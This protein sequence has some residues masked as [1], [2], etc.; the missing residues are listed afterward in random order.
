MMNSF[1]WSR[2]YFFHPKVD[3]SETS[4]VVMLKQNWNQFLLVVKACV[5][6]ASIKILSVNS[7]YRR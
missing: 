5:K 1:N 2:L 4:S 6:T 3:G 7:K